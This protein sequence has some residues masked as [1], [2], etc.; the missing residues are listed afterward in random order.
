LQG[1]GQATPDREVALRPS[2]M[3]DLRSGAKMFYLLQ[4]SFFEKLFA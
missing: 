3:A 1:C 2:G 4:V